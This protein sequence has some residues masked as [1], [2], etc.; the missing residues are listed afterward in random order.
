MNIRKPTGNKSKGTY[1]SDHA[2]LPPP[3]PPEQEADVYEKST[4]SKVSSWASGKIKESMANAKAERTHNIEHKKALRA[5]YERGELSTAYKRGQAGQPARS[6][7]SYKMSGGARSVQS[8]D[9]FG[10]AGMIGG[11][12]GLGGD[13]FGGGQAPARKQLP[14]TVTKVSKSGAV[15]IVREEVPQ[16]KKQLD[17]GFGGFWGTPQHGS[18]KKGEKH[19]YDFF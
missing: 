3:P 7:G 10:G 17:D 2:E 13:F 19:P 14:T 6:T 18:G 15:T 12:L 9:F 5:E 1:Y 11:G 8:N 4:A 16:Q